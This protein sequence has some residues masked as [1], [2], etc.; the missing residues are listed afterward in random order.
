VEALDDD[1]AARLERS[2]DLRDE[3]AQG[4]IAEDDE[5]PA[6][7]AEVEGLVALPAGRS[8]TIRTRKSLGLVL[9]VGVSAV[10]MRFQRPTSSREPRSLITV[11]RRSG[12]RAAT[13]RSIRRAGAC[14]RSPLP[15]EDLAR[16][17]PV[18]LTQ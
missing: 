6:V 2:H 13:S 12:G 4:D 11:T 17:G 18:Q 9:K 3:I 16:G 14:D 7:L 10:R 5:S 1:Q 15:A 8:L